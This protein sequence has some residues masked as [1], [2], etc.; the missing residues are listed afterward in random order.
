MYKI[1]DYTQKRAK[2][3]NLY[4][5]PSKRKNKKIDV[6]KDNKYLVSIGDIRYGDFPTFKEEYGA[7]YA[8]R[9]KL[10]Y[11]KRHKKDTKLAGKLAQYLLW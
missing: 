2:E 4:I 1:T 7:E 11:Y 10:A 9:R 3:L 5:T 6:Y 8:N